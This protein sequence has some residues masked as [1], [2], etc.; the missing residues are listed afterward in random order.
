MCALQRSDRVLLNYFSSPEELGV[1][2]AAIQV[3]ENI[4]LLGS[5]V[6]ISVAPS[7]IYMEASGVAALKKIISL[8]FL[9]FGVSLVFV[10]GLLLFSDAIILVLYGSEFVGASPLLRV[11]TV[12]V[13]LF[14]V[15]V[16]LSIFVNKFGLGGRAAIKWLLA[17]SAAVGVGCWMIPEHG[18]LGALAG[19]VAGY[20]IAVVFGAFI[21]YQGRNKVDGRKIYS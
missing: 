4:N 21:I 19:M 2:S 13:P 7:M 5:I 18:A 6:I 11:M 17:F 15:D 20:S 12:L 10:L 16:A 8:A 9:L 3:I 14:F 1:Y